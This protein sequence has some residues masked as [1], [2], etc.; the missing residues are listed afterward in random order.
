MPIREAPEASL[1][2]ARE[3]KGSYE[4]WVESRD[5][6]SV[7]FRQNMQTGS[8]PQSILDTE[9]LAETTGGLVCIGEVRR[10]HIKIDA[11]LIQAMVTVWTRPR[12]Q[13][14][15]SPCED[16]L[17]FILE[18]GR[19]EGGGR[20]KHL[21]GKQVSALYSCLSWADGLLFDKDNRQMSKACA[22]GGVCRPEIQIPGAVSLEW[23]SDGRTVIFTLADKTNRPCQVQQCSKSLISLQKQPMWGLCGL[24][25]Q[26]FSS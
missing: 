2:Q 5:A 18:S 9:L 19:Q 26:T 6:G 17:A 13:V 7:F 25:F 14:K 23:A 11:V 3:V 24:F 8:L 1:A 20:I 4:Y 10:L 15:V 12:M 21:Q 22:V 16:L